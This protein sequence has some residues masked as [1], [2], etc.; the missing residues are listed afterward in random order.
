MGEKKSLP[1]E[2][3]ALL[4]L[5]AMVLWFAGDLV[6]GG[7]VP[8]FRDL[9][10][11]FYPMRF[12][13]AQ[14]LRSGEIPLWNRHAAMGF[15]LAANFQSGAFYPP[16]LVFLFLP[17][18]DAVRFLF[19][20]HYFFAATGSYWLCRQWLFPACLALIG[21][22]LFTFGGMIVSL[23]NLLDHFQSAVWLPWVLLF[24]ERA[25]R[26]RAWKDFLLLTSF[27]LVQ[28]LAGSPEFYA[29][30]AALL[31]LD[32]LR[33]QREC[34]I[35]L[36]K[37]LFAF[38]S[39]N[40]L[41]A[42][43]AMAQILPTAEL[44]LQSWRH[45]TLPYQEGTAWSLSPLRLLNLFFLDKEINLHAHNGIHLYFGRENPLLL[46]LYLGPIALAGIVLWS[47][48][49]PLKETTVILGLAIG[50]ALL[51]MGSYTPLH[52]WLFD[53]LPLLGLIRFPEKFFFLTSMI[54]TFLALKG[55]SKLL[56]SEH[57]LSRQGLLALLLVP[58]GLFLAPYLFFRW[59]TDILIQLIAWAKQAPANDIST[60][61]IS[62]GVLVHLER[63]VLLAAGMS[64]LF[65][66]WRTRK[67]RTGLFA[68]LLVALAFLDLA[69]A[70]RPYQFALDARSIYRTPAIIEKQDNEHYRLFYNHEL[71]YLHPNYYRFS[72]RPFAQTVA[73]LFAIR[74][75]NTGIFE[76]FDYMQEIDA[77]GR[78]PY[79][80]FLKVGSDLPPERLYRLLGALN[81]KYVV[82]LQPLPPGGIAL[83]RHF[84]EFPAWLY[85]LERTVPRTYVAWSAVAEKNPLITLKRLSS[86][87][88]NPLKEVILEEPLSIPASDSFE[89]QVKILRYEHQ[90][91]TIQAALN[92]SGILVLAD[93]FYPGWKVYV[94]GEENRILRTN[95]FFRGVL[96]PPGEHLV[97]FRY[98]PYWFK[99]GLGLSIATAS[100]LLVLT[101]L[102]SFGGT[103][104][105][106]T[107]HRENV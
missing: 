19:V 42:G 89:S 34:A 77:L 61:K 74:I 35:P 70:H 22:M 106:I 57:S 105:D 33:L 52:A 44:F 7:K 95:L 55:L 66:L 3:T 15:P 38:L 45:G 8:F 5:S 103:R 56:A 21:S 84:P 17:F 2:L 62:S 81:V 67:L 41:V 54:L 4:V 73:S 64:L 37:L 87:D 24:G 79:D 68:A 96:V 85:R 99:A 11:Y 58:L 75:P 51:A 1:G 6:W 83:A 29:M 60:L 53:Y 107:T 88:F 49:S 92:S 25:L 80:L 31:L 59:R 28:F 82:S 23:T 40:A 50:F 76:G 90:R 12:N 102:S 86:Q 91:V 104:K 93:S 101:L 30:S 69:S 47:V 26:S 14:S 39:A 48:R 65:F 20:F 78:K 63:Q 43:L 9:G 27:L 13:L 100:F 97:E 16:H 32:G 10:S 72:L 94:N 36:R 98:Q 46:S 18:F 71:S